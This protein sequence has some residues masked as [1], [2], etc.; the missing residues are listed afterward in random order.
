MENHGP[1]KPGRLPGVDDPQAQYLHHV[2]NTGRM[3]QDLV[4]AFEALGRSGRSV[5]L[6]V[7]GD[8]APA[9]PT[10]KPG[11]GGQATDYAL[12]RFGRPQRPPA[13][14]DL[15][16]DALGRHLRGSIAAGPAKG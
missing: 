4:T 14:V 12:F 15:S 2:V 8:H 11:F 3:I 13:H 7:F 6:C 1:W 16:A 5:T 10:C 9:L